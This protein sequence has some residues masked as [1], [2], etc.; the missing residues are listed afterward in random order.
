LTRRLRLFGEPAE[1]GNSKA[2]FDANLLVSAFLSR[3]NPGGASNELLRFVVSG[4]VELYLFVDIIDE[5]IGILAGSRRLLTRYAYSPDEIGQFRADLMILATIIDPE[6]IP[7]AVPRDPDNDK[8]VA[9]AVAGGAEYLVTRDRDLLSL[10]SYAGIPI[11]SPETF[12][13]I[14]RE[15]S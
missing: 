11:I 2:V 7:G 3:E 15:R 10:D 5:A 6:P 4:E 8:I 1:A 9:C 13:H 12:L 14:I